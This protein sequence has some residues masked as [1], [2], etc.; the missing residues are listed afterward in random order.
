MKGHTI[1]L[2]VASDLRFVSLGSESHIIGRGWGKEKKVTHFLNPLLEKF[3]R[4]QRI[5]AINESAASA[6]T[7]T[8]MDSPFVK[9]IG[10]GI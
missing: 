9:S 2:M 7:L 10:N 5:T 8:E 3:K 6:K 4:I 1:L